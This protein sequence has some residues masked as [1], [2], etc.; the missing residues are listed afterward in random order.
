MLQAK[1]IKLQLGASP[2]FLELC[3]QGGCKA[4]TKAISQLFYMF[5]FLGFGLYP[6]LS[7]P[8]NQWQ[9]QNDIWMFK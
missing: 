6:A 2:H 5:D 4:H 3:P 1:Q 9:L 8:L 7:E